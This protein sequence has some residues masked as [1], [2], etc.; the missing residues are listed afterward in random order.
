MMPDDDVLAP[1]AAAAEAALAEKSAE[2]PALAEAAQA[3]KRDA[4]D[5]QN[6][7]DNFVLR[8]NLASRRGADLLAPAVAQLVEDERRKRD[9]AAAAATRARKLLENCDWSISCAQ[10]DLAQLELV[11]NPPS[12]AAY[13]PLVE[14][15]KRPAPA[16]LG[17]F[18]PIEFPKPPAAA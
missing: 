1:L 10:A 7:L 9:V 5:A 4:E 16:W 8:C 17:G 6:R 11:R 3:T 12:A 14:V 15:V 18:D 13:R 2:R